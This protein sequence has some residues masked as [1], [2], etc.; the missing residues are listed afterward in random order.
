MRLPNLLFTKSKLTYKVFVIP[1][2]PFFR[3]FA[4]FLY[5]RFSIWISSSHNF[6][7]VIE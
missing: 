4:S 1:L 2:L 7:N 6:F 3:F 5:L